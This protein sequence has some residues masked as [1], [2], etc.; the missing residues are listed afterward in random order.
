MMPRYFGKRAGLSIA[1]GSAAAIIAVLKTST[2]LAACT[3][4]SGA[5]PGLCTYS[6]DGAGLTIADDTGTGTPTAIVGRANGANGSGVVGSAT[7]ENGQGVFGS[8]NAAGGV[9]GLFEITGTSANGDNAAILALHNGG[10]TTKNGDYGNAGVFKIGNAKNTAPALTVETLG[11][12]FAGVFTGTNALQVKG[13]LQI[14]TSAVS[15]DVLTSDIHGNAHWATAPS[16]STG[17]QGPTGAKGVTGAAGATG[18]TGQTGAQGATGAKGVTGAAGATGATG[19]AGATGPSGAAFALPGSYTDSTAGASGAALSITESGGGDTLDLVNH[20]ATGSPNTIS[21]INSGGPVGQNG[22]YGSAGYF[23]VTN[24]S[25]LSPAINATNTTGDGVDGTSSLNNGVTGI[26]AESAG[27]SGSSTSGTGIVGVSLGDGLAALFT[28][29]GG[30]GGT[31]SYDGGANWN[32]SSDRNL[33]EHFEAVDLDLLLRRIDAMPV[34][35]YQM[36]HSRLPIRYLGPTA[37]D[38]KAAFGLGNGDT[39]INTANAQGVA[40]A[41]AKGLSRKLKADEATIAA[42]N[43]KIAM[44]GAEIAALERA[45]ARIATLNAEVAALE[46]QVASQQGV[47]DRLAQL[48][49][50]VAR[51]TPATNTRQAMLAK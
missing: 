46:E 42:Q 30:G 1:A 17:A 12:G 22:N 41:A 4:P 18:A 38:F 44:Q 40:L 11:T 2:A 47:V 48:E 29:G 13:G 32:C 37:Q 31:C 36:K 21:V 16:G 14:P 8:A 24:S 43:A 45:N 23:Q 7:G 15:G 20:A 28:G 10:S 9:G 51:L 39:M 26:S 50:A 19:P 49:A 27:V 6:G 25:N 3:L 34:F 5:T 35:T 33:K